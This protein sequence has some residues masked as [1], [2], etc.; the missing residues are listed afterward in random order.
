MNTLLKLPSYIYLYFFC[1]SINLMT[2]VIS[3]VVAAAVGNKISSEPLYATVPYGMQFLLL[4]IG[5]YPASLLMNKYGRKPGFYVGAIFLLLAGII[6][7]LS[8]AENSFLLLI[9]SHGLIGLF[10]ACANFYRYAVTD[11]LEKS[12]QSKALSLVVAGGFIAGILGP[13]ISSQLQDIAG[14]PQFSLC[15]ASFIILAFINLVVIYFLPAPSLKSSSVK[16]NCQN[17]IFL[18]D[19]NITYISIC[20]AAVGYG[21]MNLLMIQSSLQM[22]NMHIAFKDAAFAIQWHVVAMFL[23]SFFT[24]FLISKFGHIF[25]ILSGFILFIMSFIINVYDVNYNN[26]VFSLILLGLGWNFSYV[27]GSSMLSFSLSGNPEKQKWQGIGDTVIAVFATMGAMSPSFLL[28]AIGWEKTNIIAAVICFIAI[29][30]L[31][32]IKIANKG[33]LKS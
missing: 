12:L 20:V 18:Q 33:M 19:R 25:I 1:Q 17:K 30:G 8:I 26:I 14:F 29:F 13:T 11:G 23:P 4:L 15:Y 32:L 22:D 31:T 21:L 7:Y 6:G 5:T 28:N 27:G 10:T 3:V 2:A 9:I 24:G 16:S